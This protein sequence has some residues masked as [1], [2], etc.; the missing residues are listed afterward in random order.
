MKLIYLNA[1]M[2]ESNNLIQ[3][4]GTNKDVKDSGPIIFETLGSAWKNMYLIL[5][6]DSPIL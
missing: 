4:L 2:F 3:S 1:N 6:G 5:C